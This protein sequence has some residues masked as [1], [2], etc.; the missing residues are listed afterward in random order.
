[1]S[2]EVR[3][4]QSTE[5]FFQ[6]F[7]MIAHYFGGSPA[8]E[9][10]PHIAQVFEADRTLLALEGS[11]PVGGAGAHTFELTV[12]GGF[13]PAA[14][15][16]IVGVAPMKRR[17]GILRSMMR[18]Q[19]D[20]V[21]RRGEPVAY[22][23]ASE[24]S[25]YGRFGYGMSS[26]MGIVDLPKSECT[27][28]RAAAPR[29][30]FRFVGIEDGYPAIASVY[31]RV[32]GD[33][34]GMFSRREAWWK[35]R[36]IADLPSRR[37]GGGELN[38]VVLSLD[39]K[40][41]GY[42]LYRF[43]M[44]LDGGISSSTVNVVE[45][46]GTTPEATRQVW[47][48][49]FEIDWCARV[50]TMCLP[51]DHPLFFLLAHPRQMRMS[52]G[53]ALWVRLVEVEAALSARRYGQADPVV[54][55][56]TDPFCPWNDGHY[57]VDSDGAKRVDAPADLALDIEGL[58]SVYLGGFSFT[59]LALAGRAAEK[60]PGALRRADALFRSDRLPWCPEIF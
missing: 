33:Y 39:G 47:R 32:R 56:V 59:Q 52:I 41:E 9:E 35:S 28:A 46:I 26:L 30:E 18:A 23:W 25:I 16:T 13:V 55:E 17:R 29:G 21:R 7:G 54:L 43:N 12:P 2:I 4:C 53:D 38:R 19:L 57:R 58:G 44:G 24:E 3:S 22:L 51:V 11:T 10:R 42:A 49:L 34:P 20:D 15:V 45:A 60:N 48:Y 40:D 14:G 36:R 37:R 50:K 5:E 1:M 6:A 27:F 8:E 31:D